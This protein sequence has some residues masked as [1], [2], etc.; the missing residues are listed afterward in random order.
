MAQHRISTVELTAEPGTQRPL[1]AN[2]MQLYLHDFSGFAEIG[3][4]HGELGP[5]GR[6][7]YEPLDLYWTEVGRTPFTIR[8]DGRLA[9]FALINR[10]SA[11]DRPLDRA[12]AEF[13][14]VRKYRRHQVGSRAAALAFARF[15]GRWE[16]PVAAYNTPARAFWRRAISN[17]LGRPAE[18]I[19]GDGLRWAGPVFCFDTSAVTRA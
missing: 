1:F 7:A 4:A 14:V 16:V 2:L 19:G 5:D 8:V 3:T 17:F 13:F 12:M 11:L 18:E 10:W 6:F 15:P 9:G